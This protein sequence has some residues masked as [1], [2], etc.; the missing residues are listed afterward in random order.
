MSHFEGDL[1]KILNEIQNS[2]NLISKDIVVEER[3]SVFRSARRGATTEAR[4]R[5]VGDEIIERNNGWRKKERARG[6]SA[7]L[8]MIQHYTEDKLSAEMMLKFSSAL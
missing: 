4:N 8:P 1:H 5:G 6:K 7:S 2:T 3:Y